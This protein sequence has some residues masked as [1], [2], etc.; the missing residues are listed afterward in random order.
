MPELD[1]RGRQRRGYAG[2]SG[3]TRTRDAQGATLTL[4]SLKADLP[5]GPLAGVRILEFSGLGPVPFAAGI[6]ADLGARVIHLHGPAVPPDPEDPQLRGREFVELDL[7]SKAGKDNCLEL[8]R[9]CDV[10]LEG[11]RPGVMERL[12]LGPDRT[13]TVNPR[14]IY[15]RMTGWGQEGPLALRA[16][17][18]INYLAL[19]GVLNAIGPREHPAIPLNL[20]GDFGGGS[21]FLLTGVLAALH[22][23][24]TTGEGAVLDVAMIDGAAFLASSIIHKHSRGRWSLERASNYLDGAAP[25]YGVYRCLDGK[26]LAI[27]A[28][29][30]KFYA[31]LRERCGLTDTLFDDPKNQDLW[32]AQ[33]AALESVFATQPRDTWVS[34]C[35][36]AD[37]CLAPVLDF[38]EA[39]AHPHSLARRSYVNSPWGTFPA[40]APRFAGHSGIPIA[41]DRP[42]L[43]ATELIEDLTSRE[44]PIRPN[45]LRDLLAS[46]YTCRSFLP[47]QVPRCTIERI[48]QIAALTPSWCN[49]QPWQVIVTEGDATK[50]FADALYTHAKVMGRGGAP[51]FP[52]PAGYSGDYDRRR[53]EV[54]SQLYESI[55]IKRGDREATDRQRM[56]NFRFFGAPH[57][58]IITSDRH[59]G[60]YGAI[61][62]GAFVSN[63][64]LAARDHGVCSA[65]QAAPAAYAPF[66]KEYFGIGDDRMMICAISFGYADQSSGINKFRTSRLEIAGFTSFVAN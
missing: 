34:L 48:L 47:T 5:Q 19:S 56:E 17:H 39:Q 32:P 59:M 27:G 20:I 12:N 8:V 25:W 44:S 22:H 37:C 16:G 11:F 18:D 51:D 62:C 9:N 7:K 52:F 43:S 10:L 4:N 31:Q 28:I 26:F 6:L 14:L 13:A 23:A 61:D 50:R 2:D 36:G 3:T 15:G 29:E 65:P 24:R 53:R 42:A 60:T 35:D 21:M 49:T 54:G 55:G 45:S 41:Q 40:A 33:R 66:I 46:R 1:F 30:P 38:E 63:F 64:L 57:V 58:A